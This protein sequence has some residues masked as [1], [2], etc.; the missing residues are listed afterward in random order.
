M[1]VSAHACFFGL[2]RVCVQ[3]GVCVSAHARFCRNVYI[4]AHTH[5]YTYTE[6]TSQRGLRP[7]LDSLKWPELG[8]LIERMWAD[9]PNER[10][11]A[12]EILETLQRMDGSASTGG[13]F[14]T[15]DASNKA[16]K[17]SLDCQCAVM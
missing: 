13:G 7:P 12:T 14:D 8:A 11:G 16:I 4:H 6:L 10:P 2:V 17:C 9:A 5:I 1:F 15:G 3:V